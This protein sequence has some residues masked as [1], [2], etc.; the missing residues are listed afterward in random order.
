MVGPSRRKHSLEQTEDRPSAQDCS[1]FS[2]ET[3]L[4]TITFEGVAAS[5][6]RVEVLE[7]YFGHRGDANLAFSKIP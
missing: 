7:V 4:L 5:V 3:A 1:A 2:A 6:S